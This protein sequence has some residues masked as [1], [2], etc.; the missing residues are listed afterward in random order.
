[1]RILVLVVSLVPAV[2]ACAG[3]TITVD[4][5]GPA[6]FNNIQAAINDASDGDTIIVCPGT[7]SGPETGDIEFLGKAVTVRSTDPNNQQVVMD[8]VVGSRFYFRHG[9]DANSVLD[10]LTVTGQYDALCCQASSPT[11]RRC[12]FK[13][14]GPDRGGGMT[15]SSGSSPVV[16]GCSFDECHRG[17][18]GGIV[19]NSH[20]DTRFVDCRFTGDQSTYAGAAV[21]NE[22]SN[23]TFLRCTF[24]RNTAAYRGGGAIYN[25]DSNSL[26]VACVFRDNSGE[27]GALGSWRSSVTA[28]NC[29]FADN[30]GGAGVLWQRQSTATLKNCTLSGNSGGTAGGIYCSDSSAEIENC[31]LWGNKAPQVAGETFV[32]THSDVQGGWPGEGNIDADPSF[33]QS[34]QGAFRLGPNSPCINA[35]DNS[36]VP[37]DVLTDLQGYPRISDA[38]V[39]MGCYEYGGP[40]VIYVDGDATGADTGRSWADAYRYLQSAMFMAVEGDEI[41]VA[42]GVYTPD[43][44]LWAV[45][46]DGASG[47]DAQRYY[48]FNLRNAIT[49]NGGYPGFGHDEP[50]ARDIRRYESIL[51]GDRK[52]DD[53]YRISGR[54]DN[55]FNV[56]TCFCVDETA[57]LDGFSIIGG[58]GGD[59]HPASG[60]GGGLYNA[61]G[62]PLVRNCTFTRNSATT[63]AGI[64]SQNCTSGLCAGQVTEAN[65]TFIN[66]LVY[67]NQAKGERTGSWWGSPWYP[68]GSAWDPPSDVVDGGGIRC[69][70]GKITLINC[71]ITRNSG[72]GL[73]VV[74]P[75]TISNSIIW[76]NYPY[77]IGGYEEPNQVSVTHSAVGGGWQGAGNI[78]VDPLI[79]RNG[80]L[81]AGSPCIDAGDPGRAVEPGETDIDGEPRI[82][83]PRFDGDIDIGC[84]EFSDTDG[85]LL[86]D[87]WEVRHFGEPNAAGAEDD[88]DGDGWKNL[89]EYV[90]YTLPNAE[91]TTF[92]VDSERGDYEYDGLA[93]EWDGTHGPMRVIAQATNLCRPGHNDTVVLAKGLYSVGPGLP[94]PRSF[95]YGKDLTLR[96]MDPSDPCVVAGTV[97]IGSTHIIHSEGPATVLDGVTITWGNVHEG[98]QFGNIGNGNGGGIFCRSASPTIRRCV[99]TANRA[100]RYGGGIY[101]DYGSPTIVDCLIS[102]NTAGYHGGGICSGE[103]PDN[104]G[105]NPVIKNCRITDN[106]AA[107]GGAVDAF[108]GA[109]QIINCVISGNRARATG[110]IGAVG[111]SIH[112]VNCTITGNVS[113]THAATTVFKYWEF[114][115]LPTLDNCIVWANEP[116]EISDR[117]GCLAVS[118]SDVEGGWAGIGNID[119]DP[120]FAKAGHWDPN[121]TVEDA[122]D[123][124]W[125]EGDYHLKSAGWRLDPQRA[126]WRWDDVTSLCIDAGNPGA[127]LGDEPLV[128]PVDPN[129]Q[130]GRNIRINM[131][132]YGGTLEASMAPHGWALRADLNNDGAVDF[133]DLSLWSEYWLRWGAAPADLDR[134]GSVDAGDY[135]LIADDW[136]LETTW[137]E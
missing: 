33:P 16:I 39:D 84:D 28:I 85:D 9:E 18:F 99:I 115:T 93:P 63:G 94:S 96:S 107:I 48:S 50:D 23:S 128:L 83:P 42:E 117:Y 137:R 1:M 15:N 70:S 4:D 47:E 136:L 67:D 95:S 119:A 75:T 89:D 126:L 13:K 124:F 37:A 104:G 71:T 130:W 80:R 72:G 82:G 41:R 69:R 64:F 97:I 116:N 112:A 35:G 79:T 76:D 60:W 132:A 43:K 62:S 53:V 66:C 77:Q 19:F 7:Y 46:P 25:K 45:P 49:V 34:S 110:G 30:P 81:R 40:R 31:V 90:N 108:G 29:L 102:S 65:P 123:D 6:D 103:Y 56:V 91:P 87:V 127:P 44:W 125:V 17:D 78:D 109:P 92:Y 120:C 8:T 74:T 106:C 135:A 22:D 20:S 105:K 131:G 114:E 32:I 122:N 118:C 38:N 2:F 121:G 52:A 58:I 68:P 113:E 59:L 111:S 55:S 10:G 88:P 21:C 129:N 5:D 100:E 51:S 26:I 101:I 57:V 24:S 98:R 12:T 54:T 3:A 61:G 73:Y 36:A 133:T 134:D 86:P 11:I 27:G 14:S